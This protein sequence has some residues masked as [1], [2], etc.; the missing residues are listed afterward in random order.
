M[1]WKERKMTDELFKRLKEYE[2]AKIVRQEAWEKIPK[3]CP[4]YEM[5]PA[6]YD[7]YESAYNHARDKA[8][9]IADYLIILKTI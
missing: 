9:E 4:F 2:Q 5:A 1:L 8:V 7:N 3:N 6:E